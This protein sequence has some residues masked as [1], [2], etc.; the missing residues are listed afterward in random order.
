LTE[1]P[2][3]GSILPETLERK[4]WCGDGRRGGERE[5]KRNKDEKVSVCPLG[6]ELCAKRVLFT[7]ADPTPIA[8]LCPSWVLNINLLID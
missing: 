8:L 1:N 3:A 2:L 7:S 5:L 6:Q 4:M